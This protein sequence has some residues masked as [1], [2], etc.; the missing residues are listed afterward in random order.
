VNQLTT[1]LSSATPKAK[2][3]LA[4]G[5]LLT[6]VVLFL[7]F[8]L[9][10]APSYET[11][12]TG[13]DPADTAK[14]TKALDEQGIAYELQNGGTALGVEGADAPRARIALAEQGLPG[15][16]Q[17]GFELFDEQKLGT[18]DF[19]Q[20][21]NYQRA[22][23]GEIA[24]TVQ[25]VQGVSGAKVQLVLPDDQLFA[26]DRQPATA[27]VLLNGDASAI[28]PGAVR[29]M[30][31]LVASSVQGLAVDKVTITDGSGR[32]L[33]PQEGADAAGGTLSKAAAEQRH[34]QQLA[35]QLTAMLARTVGPD[36]AQVQVNSTLNLDKAK[37]RRL[38]YE[39]RGVALK[40]QTEREQLE[41][42]GGAAGGRAGAA[43]NVPGYAGGAAA[44]GGAS[45]YE[46]RTDNTDYGVG[47]TVRDVEFAQGAVEKQSVAVVLDA[48]VP[49][50][51]AR[52]LEAAVESA[53]GIDPGRG[54]QLTVSRVA[55]A[56]PPAEAAPSAVDGLLPHAKWGALGLASLVFLLLAMRSIRRRERE[57]LGE[58][59]W[60][61]EITAP[62]PLAALEAES[63]NAQL[64][65]AVA[66]RANLRKRAEQLATNEPQK[67]AQ[68]LRSWMQEEA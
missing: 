26:E 9:A 50:A 68:Q 18:S 27:A 23:E 49:P 41:G 37:E 3:G 35:G 20:Q 57:A 40:R 17:P 51:V 34:E 4:A 47:K 55:F 36:K 21:V 64:E 31:Q 15:K 22:L 24:K 28:E 12:L 62:Q 48:S 14:V 7:L 54:D 42:G 32:L 8:R 29:G 67:A 66:E 45:N 60:L 13:I 6:L 33:W 58:P 44:G 2:A 65:M 52:E 16:G 63:P 61:R 19:Q 30:A 25:G 10:T 56:K 1:L 59:V 39:R 5:A 11:M 53:A 46:R 38:T 43:G